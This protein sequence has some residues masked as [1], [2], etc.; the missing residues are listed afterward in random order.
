[1]HV[2]A[3]NRVWIGTGNAGLAMLDV[4]RKTFRYYDRSS[5]PAHRQRRRL[6]DPSHARRDRSGSAPPMAACTGWRADGAITRFMPR[7][8]DPRSLPDA[9]VG[10]LAVAPDG[11]L[12]V[13]TKDGVARW[14]GRDFERLPASALNTPAVNG[15]TIDADGALWIGTPRGVSVRH[16]D[17]S[18]DL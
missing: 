5:D 11:T 13:G 14:T 15:L 2:D 4:D 10:Q 9:G 3:R 17:G 12:W 18:V 1:M 6:V 7:A 16:A 8:D